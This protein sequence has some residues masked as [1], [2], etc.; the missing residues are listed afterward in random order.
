MSLTEKEN[1]II[2]MP[3]ASLLKRIKEELSSS[4]TS[5][6]ATSKRWGPAVLIESC[7]LS[8]S[9]LARDAQRMQ[10]LSAGPHVAVGSDIPERHAHRRGCGELH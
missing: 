1:V 4:Q 10:R 2:R 8:G 5:A 6:K 9:F 3:P 7:A